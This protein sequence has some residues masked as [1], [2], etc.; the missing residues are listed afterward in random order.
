MFSVNTYN[1]WKVME[2]IFIKF[3]VDFF[4]GYD[5]F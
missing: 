4:V 1:T 3:S 2:G 5:E